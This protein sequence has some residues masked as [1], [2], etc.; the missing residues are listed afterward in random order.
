[1]ITGQ[2]TGGANLGAQ[3]RD[4]IP[5]IQSGLQNEVMRLALKMTALVMVKLSGEVLKVG[6]GVHGGN[7]SG[8]RLRGSIHPEWDLKPGYAGATVGTNVEYAAI[9]EYGYN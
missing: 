5:D 4:S 2:V 6:R 1:M 3:F 8:G 9:H 7:G